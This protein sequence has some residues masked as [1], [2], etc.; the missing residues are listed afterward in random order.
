MLFGQGKL[1]KMVV[2]AFLPASS[3]DEAPQV[4]DSPDDTYVV[5]VNPST[6]T[7]SQALNYASRQGQGDSGSDAVYTSSEP[8]ELEFKFLF[9][10][11]GVVPPPSELGDVPLIGAI[12]SALSDSEEYVVM[13]EIEKFNRVVYSY[14]GEIHRPRKVLLVW[15]ALEFACALTSLNYQFTLFKPDGTPLRAIADCSFQEAMPDNL[16]ELTESNSS[17]DLSHRREV[18]AGDTLPLMSYR[19]YGDASRYLE[20]ARYNK[21]VN[22]RRLSPGAQLILPRVDDE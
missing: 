15:G 1:E 19:V 13:E 10:A 11:T 12:A 9:D 6:F 4:S 14:D 3:P 17:P 2:R 21:I 16:R 20:V 5:Q 22:F 18:K 7:L 8:K